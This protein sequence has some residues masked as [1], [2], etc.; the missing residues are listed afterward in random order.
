MLF[1]EKIC[2]YCRFDKV[3]KI[4]FVVSQRVQKLHHNRDIHECSVILAWSITLLNILQCL[5]VFCDVMLHGALVNGHLQF[6]ALLLLELA[7]SCRCVG[8][9]KNMFSCKWN[10]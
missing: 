8:R 3:N 4:V 6:D 5:H 9:L 2:V 1:S 7:E 10:P